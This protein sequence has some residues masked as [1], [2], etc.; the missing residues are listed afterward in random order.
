MRSLCLLSVTAGEIKKT[1]KQTKP[2]PNQRY[3][4]LWL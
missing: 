1:N 4:F 2:K 3:Y